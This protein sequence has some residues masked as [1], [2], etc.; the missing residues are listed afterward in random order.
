MCSERIQKASSLIYIPKT[1]DTETKKLCI[2]FFFRQ[3]HSCVYE[4]MF[5]LMSF[6]RCNHNFQKANFRCYEVLN[7]LFLKVNL[8]TG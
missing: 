2:L 1:G 3:T 5:L 8:V 6:I 7:N 4:K